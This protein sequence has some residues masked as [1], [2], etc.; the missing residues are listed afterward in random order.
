MRYFLR[1]LPIYLCVL[2]AIGL[3]Q[4]I[5][6]SLEVPGFR[7]YKPFNEKIDVGNFSHDRLNAAVFFCTN[8][9]RKKHNLNQL[10]HNAGLEAAA[11]L[12]SRDMAKQGFFSHTNPKIKKHRE[13]KDRALM[14]GIQNPHIAENIIEGFILGYTSGQAVIIA[15]KGVFYDKTNTPLPVRTYL[16]LA[17]NLLHQWMGSEGH[18]ANI[19]SADAIEMGCG[20][21]IYFMEEFNDMPAVKAT[22]NFQWFVPVITE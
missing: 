10:K 13:P 3:S 17:D 2:P 8:E 15:G 11:N 21:A 6:D 22:Q 7:Q 16:E 19:L 9:I 18:K 4:S 5:Y 14:V 20:S 1:F 12:H